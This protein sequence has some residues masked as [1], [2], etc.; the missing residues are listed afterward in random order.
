MLPVVRDVVHGIEAGFADRR[1]NRCGIVPVRH[2]VV[3]FASE[4]MFSLPMKYRNLV[5]GRH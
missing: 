5:T 4:G 2:E 3:Y 1:R